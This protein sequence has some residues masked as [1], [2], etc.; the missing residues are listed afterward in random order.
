M[1]R[2]AV[3]AV[4]IVG[5]AAL[6]PL[7]AHSAGFD[8]G[9]AKKPDE[10][11][12]C[13]NPE[14]SGLDSQMTGLWYGYSKVPMFMGARGA[15][16]DEAQAFL[17]RRAACGSDA[18]CLAAAYRER[19]GALE[20]SLDGAMNTYSRL[21]NGPAT[22]NDAVAA[23]VSGYTGQC[24]AAGGTL[25]PGA[26]Q[27]WTMT[28]DLD[29]DDLQDYVLNTQ[30]LE[31]TGSATAFCGN[32]GCQIDIALSREGFS[33]QTSMLGGQPTLVQSTAG[34]SLQVWVDGTNCDLV[35]GSNKECWATYEW[36]N[37]KLDTSYSARAAAD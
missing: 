27:P 25:A 9:K 15:R 35:G 16:R 36:S 2:F 21:L 37:G 34:T 19:I 33:K 10:I 20:E 6:A 18:E 1:I 11:A 7:P 17:A 31:C 24:T 4:A 13:K 12:V 28:A 14:L 32:G 23:I 22:P 26:D 30:G 8:C 3:A 29:G 5:P